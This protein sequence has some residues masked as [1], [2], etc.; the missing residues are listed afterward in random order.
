MK[1]CILKVP[2][3]HDENSSRE[4]INI[5]K[6]LIGIEDVDTNYEEGVANVFYDERKTSIDKIVEIVEY[7]G[8]KVGSGLDRS[9]AR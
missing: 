8:F 9:S 6:G 7:K 5:I 2:S 4:I 1:E 3:M